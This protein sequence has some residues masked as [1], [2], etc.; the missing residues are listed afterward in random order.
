MKNMKTAFPVT[1]TMVNDFV[2]K[3]METNTASLDIKDFTYGILMGL[4][5]RLVSSQMVFPDPQNEVMRAARNQ[6]VKDGN[7]PKRFRK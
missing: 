2:I 1:T 4:M 3:T 6:A 7:G 5:E